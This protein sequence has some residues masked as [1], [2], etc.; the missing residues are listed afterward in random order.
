M[1]KITPTEIVKRHEQFP[2]A[3][4]KLIE[5][6]AF[7]EYQKAIADLERLSDM[8]N[9]RDSDFTIIT[10]TNENYEKW[11]ALQES[12]WYINTEITGEIKQ[13]ACK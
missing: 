4:A 1:A 10:M 11:K 3:T 7:Q 13:R 2:E 8:V 5:A 9:I 12:H 6:Y